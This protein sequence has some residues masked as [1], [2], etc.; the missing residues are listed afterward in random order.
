MLPAHSISRL[1]SLSSKKSVCM[2][3]ICN[4]HTVQHISTDIAT[5]L[6]LCSDNSVLLV[7]CFSCND[8]TEGALMPGGPDA[9]IQHYFTT[10]MGVNTTDLWRVQCTLLDQSTTQSFLLM[11]CVRL[12]EEK[13]NIPRIIDPNYC[14]ITQWSEV[15]IDLALKLQNK[16]VL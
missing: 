6:S 15:C 3:S 2:K 5:V 8:S 14:S 13:V 7:L 16:C 11:P 1:L 10:N 9:K 12:W 4:Y